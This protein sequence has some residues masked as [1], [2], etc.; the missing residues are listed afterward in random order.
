MTEPI[1]K[2][3]I[4]LRAETALAKIA[5]RR[6]LRTVGLLLLAGVFGLFAIGFMNFA[7]LEALL[8]V[9]TPAGA[10]LALAV[11]NLLVLAVLCWLA[12]GQPK[13]SDTEQL[14]NQVREMAY[15]SLEDEAAALHRE[16]REFA[17]DVRRI[18]SVFQGVMGAVG[19]PL[20]YLA[21]SLFGA[22]DR[23]SGDEEDRAHERPSAP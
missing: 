16:M 19:G 20:S 2:V 10:G 15:A 18:R 12:L 13:D 3:Q 4:A 17:R 6:T 1:K 21:S 9:L 14:A 8:T 5:L 7:A 23:D 11:G 22:L